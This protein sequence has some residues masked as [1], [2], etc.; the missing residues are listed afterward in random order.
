MKDVLENLSIALGH[1]GEI[2]DDVLTAARSMRRKN[3]HGVSMSYAE[4]NTYALNRIA[5][6]NSQR[7]Q[8]QQWK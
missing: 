3:F 8:G 4:I 7:P 6:E 5:K 2:N 1:K